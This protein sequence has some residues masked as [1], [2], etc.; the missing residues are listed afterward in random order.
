MTNRASIVS[1]LVGLFPKAPF[2][3]G[4]GGYSTE[5]DVDWASGKK[6]ESCHIVWSTCF[7]ILLFAHWS[8]LGNH[9]GPRFPVRSPRLCVTEP[10]VDFLPNSWFS[11]LK[12]MD[13]DLD[14]LGEPFCVTNVIIAETV[15]GSSDIIPVRIPN[16]SWPMANRSFPTFAVFFLLFFF[17]LLSAF[18]SLW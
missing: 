16:E 13:D 12:I 14:L 18:P 3:N 9:W 15:R 6:R 8:S 2:P 10:T 5:L 1:C 4:I 7:S 17:G 11:C